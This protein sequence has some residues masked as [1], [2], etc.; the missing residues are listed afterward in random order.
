VAFSAIPVVLYLLIERRFRT[1]VL[2]GLLVGGLGTAAWWILN[3]ISGGYFFTGAVRGNLCG[4]SLRHGFWAG[5]AFL[6]TPLGV[7]AAALVLGL[8]V[9]QP[10]RA[11]RSVYWIGWITSTL[12]ATALSCKEG[13]TSSYF[14]ESCALGAVLLGVEG[15]APLWSLHRGR[16]LAAGLLVAAAL[17]APDVQF[18]RQHGLRL[19]VLP[20]GQAL[21]AQRLESGRQGYVLADGQHLAAVL[22]AGCRPLVNDPFLFRVLVEGGVLS[23]QTVIGALEQGTVKYLVLKRT[24]ESHREQLGTL[25][26]KW[27]AA[28]VEALA[29]YY[30]LDAT[31]GEDIFIYRHR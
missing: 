20:Y 4:M 13:S 10:G 23:P 24:V 1:A 11:M 15:L 29:R 22:H 12:I 18:I 9:C 6:A 25:S 19:P 5:H 30:V 14:L 28:V 17:A 21:I 8:F 31:G 27:P 2:Y 16:A 3:R 26:Q 7:A